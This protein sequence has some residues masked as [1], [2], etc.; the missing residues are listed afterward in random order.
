M[1]LIGCVLR[2]E[3]LSL[4]RRWSIQLARIGWMV[5]M[6]AALGYG[7]FRSSDYYWDNAVAPMFQALI[8][9]QGIAILVLVPPLTVA[10]ILREVEQNTLGLLMLT[11]LTPRAIMVQKLVAHLLF[12]GLLLAWVLPLCLAITGTGYVSLAMVV[13]WYGYLAFLFLGAVLAGLISAYFMRRL[14]HAIAVA[15]LVLIQLYLVAQ[16]VPNEWVA[17]L[18]L[19]ISLLVMLILVT[20]MLPHLAEYGKPPS[21]VAALWTLIKQHSSP[22]RWWRKQTG[23]ATNRFATLRGQQQV[24]AGR[25]PGWAYVW[26]L[27]IGAVSFGI[28]HY[29]EVQQRFWASKLTWP[30]WAVVPTVVLMLAVT[31][32]PVA[33]GLRAAPRHGSPLLGLP[34]SNRHFVLVPFLGNLRLV[35]LGVLLPVGMLAPP[36]L[37]EAMVSERGGWT[38][39]WWLLEEQLPRLAMAVAIGVL[40]LALTTYAAWRS[41]NRTHCLLRLGGFGSLIALALWGLR[42]PIATRWRWP[43]HQGL[44]REEVILWLL[45]VPCL[46]AAWL[47][48]WLTLRYL[49]RQRP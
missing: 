9:L 8:T 18:V 13:E 37:V 2:K 22:R 31:A 47:W 30:E 6:V 7:L 40:V 12:L 4:A 1:K 38:Q 20:R 27:A 29:L 21:G 34:V 44:F 19:A 17:A 5:A 16:V 28:V 36:L 26:V 24:L 33:L 32:L 35:I 45:L 15:Y 3:L 41:R 25:W 49:H 48:L 11:H 14:L 23:T 42:Y 10:M 43:H 39:L 46:A